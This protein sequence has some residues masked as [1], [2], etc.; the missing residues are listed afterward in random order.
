MS[1]T[2]GNFTKINRME[3]LDELVVTK[4]TIGE[5]RR[6]VINHVFPAGNSTFTLSSKLH[7]N[8][9]IMLDNRLTSNSSGDVATIS[10]P[11]IADKGM[12]GFS[13]TI[14]LDEPNSGGGDIIVASESGDK[15]S[16]QILVGPIALGVGIDPSTDRGVTIR[17]TSIAGDSVNVLF[18]GFNYNMLAIGGVA[19]AITPIS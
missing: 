17:A 11:S 13:C 7:D 16:G 8:S 10:L 4:A 18:N 6:R 15:T 3:V 1:T 2:N 14:V 19:G 12:A 9:I 5:N